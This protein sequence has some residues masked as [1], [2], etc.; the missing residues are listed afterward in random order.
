[1]SM[2][3][4]RIHLRSGYQA[5]S[6]VLTSKIV[7]NDTSENRYNLLILESYHIIGTS[8]TTSCGNGI[9]NIDDVGSG[10]GRDLPIIIIQNILKCLLFSPYLSNQR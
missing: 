7:S 8:G 10:M 5:R 6:S 9:Y 2:Y 4:R 3:L 1:M